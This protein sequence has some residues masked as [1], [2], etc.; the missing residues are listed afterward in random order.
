MLIS[1]PLPQTIISVQSHTLHHDPDVF[2]S[3][4]KYDPARWLSASSDL[5]AMRE[6]FFA[7]SRGSRACMGMHLATMQ[8]KLIISAL[9][10]GWDITPAEGTTEES[11]AMCDHFIA[12]PWDKACR[13]VFTP[14]ID[15]EG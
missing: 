8:L 10:W 3:P 11:M 14:V 7:W 1:G 12:I 2:P 5:N 9:V 15:L 6:S 4:Y 13:L